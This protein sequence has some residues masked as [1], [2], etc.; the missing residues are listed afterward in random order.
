M[1]TLHRL[2]DYIFT[3]NI[4]T[5]TYKVSFPM[6]AER[7]PMDWYGEPVLPGYYIIITIIARFIYHLKYIKPYQG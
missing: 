7:M 2:L 3:F 1:S 4:L 6:D 5:G